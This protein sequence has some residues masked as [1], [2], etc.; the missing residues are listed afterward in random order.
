MQKAT[1]IPGIGDLIS[2]QRSLEQCWRMLQMARRRQWTHAADILQ[3][4]LFPLITAVHESSRAVH[5]TKLA[6]VPAIG[7]IF[8]EI[9]HLGDE[10]DE[11]EINKREKY[12]AVTTDE[13]TLEDVR[14]GAFSIQLHFDRLTKRRDSSAF[15]IIALDENA[16]TG[17][18]SVTHPHVR[19]ESLCAGDAL[20]PITS[21]LNE[22][23]VGDAFQLVNRVLHTYNSSSPYVA[24]EDWES[25][26]CRDCGSQ[27]RSDS[28]YHCETCE[29]DFCDS[30]MRTC[31]SCQESVCYGCSEE[32]GN[33]DRLC[34]SCKTLDEQESEESGEEEQTPI[35]DDPIHDP[36]EEEQPQP[37]TE[38][39]HEQSIPQAQ[40]S[41]AQLPGGAT[42]D[43]EGADEVAISAPQAA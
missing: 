26:S 2:D 15:K 4:R 23:R 12:I 41:G 32:N 42:D 17:D 29:G 11:V 3:H 9:Q 36:T 22:G 19:A 8:G 1:S 21:A 5:P 18:S 13:I 16:A 43:G 40:P 27:T 33:G 7:E 35:S 14:L 34:P 25:R 20:S 24:I 38:T 6:N 28:L 37:P 39:I 10:Y 30:C 31:D